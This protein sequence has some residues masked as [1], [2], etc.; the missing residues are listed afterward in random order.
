MVSKQPAGT[1]NFQIEL[2]S[3]FK[4]YVSAVDP[5]IADAHVLVRGSQNVYKKISG[6]V[7]NRPGKKLYD[8]SVDTTLAKVNSGFVWNTSLGAT[9]PIRCANG[10]LQFYSTIS[11]TG[12]WY[13]LLTG[14]T[15]T[16][17]VFDTYWDTTDKKDKLLT[18]N[19]DTQKVY[20][21]AGGVALFISYAGSVITLDRNAAAA[22]FASSG[23]V[24]IGGV[25]YTY[26]GVSGSTLTGTSDASAATANAVAYSKVITT[27]SFTS[28]PAS[29]YT[30]DFIRVVDNQLYLGSYTSQLIYL[31]KNTTYSDFGSG[32]PRVTGEGDTILLDAPGR[33]IGTSQGSA[34]IFYGTSHL[35]KITFN[36]ITVGSILSEQVKISKVPL[37]ENSAAYA[38]EFIDSL[39]DN[40]LYLD[41]SQQLRSFGNFRNIF[42]TKAV[43]LS[44][45]VQ[46][47]LAQETFTLGQLKV[48]S[49]RRGD[50][51][52]IT[53]PNSGKVYLYQ[54]RTSLD[55][56]GN[57]IAERLWQP[58][59]L[60]NITRVD[61]IG[62]CTVGFSNSNP[63][64]YYL[65]DTN[66]WYD[67]AP[68]A[69]QRYTSIAL[70]SYE[71]G[72]R[73]QGKNSFDK[74]YYE[75]YMTS[76]SNVYGGVYYDYEGAT[77]MLNPTINDGT[78]PLI[79]GKQTFIGVVPPSLGDASLGDNPLGDGLNTLPDTQSLVPKFRVIVGVQLIDNFEH[80]LM[81]YS[82]NAGARWELLAIGTNIG[83][84]Q[85]QAVEIQK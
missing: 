67:D 30:C 73:R 68:S 11:G 9:F 25:D 76:N 85:N 59:Q 19:G 28:G 8:A 65:W 35:A 41:Q 22:G 42:T 4:G 40:I 69:Q 79:A 24:R 13:D 14:L 50:L 15:L 58:P 74:I 64:I 18:V 27:T 34:H 31:S 71:N 49:D 5:T 36:Q 7:S 61:A 53:A 45:A 29:T 39:S 21:W 66:Q 77:A 52:Y 12:A 1:D 26:T 47:E 72:G 62:G 46:E 84:S 75:G 56:T 82:T 32:T 37:G 83:V 51:V 16:R 17:F 23:S 63:Q 6:T 44:Q 55:A 81:I 57:V 3:G 70:F 2:I 10:K 54:E 78:S 43:L 60:W 20:D 38:H 33:G 48:V 80:A